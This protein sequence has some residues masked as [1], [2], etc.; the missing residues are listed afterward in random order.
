V[1]KDRARPF[2]RKHRKYWLTVTG[3]MLVIAAID[4]VLGFVF[5]PHR[6]DEDGPRQPIKFDVPQVKG[7]WARLTDA[8]VEPD[9]VPQA[10]AP[11]AAAPPTATRP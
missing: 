2:S 7:E 1:A 5:W 8:G 3:G 4:L 6:G 10:A 11:Q 9:A